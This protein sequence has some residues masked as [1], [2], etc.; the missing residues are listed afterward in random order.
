ME[1]LASIFPQV[2]KTTKNCGRK[3]AKQYIKQLLAVLFLGLENELGRSTAIPRKKVVSGSQGMHVV[4][5]LVTAV[6]EP[7]H[8][9]VLSPQPFILLDTS[10]QD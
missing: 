7:Q 9:K 8:I 6:C 3:T 5:G 2:I 10:N 4:Q 1:L